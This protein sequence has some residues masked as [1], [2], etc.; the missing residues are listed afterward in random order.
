MRI[1]REASEMSGEDLAYL[2]RMIDFVPVYMS[3][4]DAGRQAVVERMWAEASELT[5]SVV[6]A[7]WTGW[8]HCA[9]RGRGV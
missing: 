1:E 8:I 2:N 5:S 3:L 9:T 7:Y 4:P 6:Q